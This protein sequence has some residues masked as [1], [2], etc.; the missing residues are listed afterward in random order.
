MTKNNIV[1]NICKKIGINKTACE[2]VLDAFAEE[3]KD[4]LVN[5][6]KLIIKGFIGFEVLERPERKGRN[7]KTGEVITFPPAKVVKCK[8]SKAIKDAVS[9]K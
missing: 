5:G 4:C 3:V 7:P 9:G 8:L 2:E 1:E 6:D